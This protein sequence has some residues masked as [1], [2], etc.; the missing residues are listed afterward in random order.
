MSG[1]EEIIEGLKDMTEKLSA[2][3]IDFVQSIDEKLTYGIGLTE[4][5]IN[6]VNQIW[7]ERNK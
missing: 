1:V 6:I 5:H 2:W 3:E 4:N 7:D